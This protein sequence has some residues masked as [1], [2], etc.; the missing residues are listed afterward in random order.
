MLVHV[1]NIVND[2][3]IDPFVTIPSYLIH[4]CG[5]MGWHRT[6]PINGAYMD[7][8]ISIWSQP[9]NAYGHRILPLCQVLWYISG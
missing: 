8:V 4:Y 2:P 3:Y 1:P 9:E 7:E 5:M 6:E